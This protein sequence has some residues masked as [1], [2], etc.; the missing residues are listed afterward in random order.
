MSV[1]KDNNKKLEKGYY[2]FAIHRR[3]EGITSAKISQMIKDKFNVEFHHSTIRKWFSVK[4]CLYKDYNDY[5]KL[6]NRL[7][8]QETR[9]FLKGNISK[10]AKALAMC[11]SG[12]GNMTMVV[13]ANSF[14]D[15]GL[16]KP[17]DLEDDEDD[18]QVENKI[19]MVEA[20]KL[21]ELKDINKQIDGA[22]QIS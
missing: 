6:M 14:L 2:Q 4:G 10:A 3:Y 8:R 21:L 9:D 17:K 7:E 5:A 18:E 13:A 1:A 12:Q 20:L 11:I 15:R 19:G 16:G 22:K